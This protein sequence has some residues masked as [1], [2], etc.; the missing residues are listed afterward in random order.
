MN[1][2][3]GG[4]SPPQVPTSFVTQDGIAVPALNI[5]IVNAYDT[6]Q[7]NDN[8]IETKGGVAGGNP[9]GTGATNETDIYLTN[10]VTGAVTTADA[11]LTT[12]I[13]LPMG[14]A[15][16]TYMVFGNVQAFNASTPAGA[17]YGFSGAFRTTGAA[18]VEIATEYHDEFE[19][20]AFITADIFLSAS[21]NNILLQVQGVAATSINWNSLLEYRMVT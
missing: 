5:L 11:T 2:T 7:N 14:A 21:G 3:S 13:T 19:E 1:N 8:G 16:A 4:P 9:P 12:I 18:A 10:R 6:S 15:P 17:S 20:A